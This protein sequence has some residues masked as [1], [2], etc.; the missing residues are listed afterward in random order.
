MK[1]DVVTL[2]GK[3]AGTVDVSDAVFG[4][5]PRSDIL[6]RMVRWQLAKRQ[7]GT[8]KTKTRSDVARVKA[9]MYRQK[10]T[11]GARHGARSAPQFTGGGKAHG[12]VVRSH[13]HDLPKKV[14]RLALK[15]AL[16]SKVKGKTLFVLDDAKLE[17]PKTKSLV[18]AFGKLGFDNAL[19]VGG[20]SPDTNFSLAARNLP[21]VDVIPVEA[22][23]VYDVLRRKAL[24]LTKGALEHLEAR[25]Q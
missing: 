22:I 6:H 17:A 16:S 4:L 8:H 1:M 11:G 10:G 18:V 2:E 13:E 21:S 19:V 12:P 3:K 20:A 7:A 5:D 24:V 14:R 9:K 25:L 23:N 15:H